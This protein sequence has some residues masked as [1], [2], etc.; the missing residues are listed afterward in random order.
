MMHIYGL[1]HLQKQVIT[2]QLKTDL[3]KWKLGEK[4][5]SRQEVWKVYKLVQDMLKLKVKDGLFF[6]FL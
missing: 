1:T 5:G 6:Q 4:L 3:K 2:E